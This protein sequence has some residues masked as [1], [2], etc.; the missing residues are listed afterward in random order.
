M[1]MKDK[2]CIINKKMVIFIIIEDYMYSITWD[3]RAYSE[4]NY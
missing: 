3:R 1:K 4:N 2:C